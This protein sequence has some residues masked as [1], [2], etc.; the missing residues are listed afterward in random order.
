MEVT[1]DASGSSDTEGGIVTLEWDCVGDG[2]FEAESDWTV[3]AG[4]AHTCTYTVDGTYEP[5]VRATN[6]LVSG[7][8]HEC[9]QVINVMM[10]QDGRGQDRRCATRTYRILGAKP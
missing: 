5:S 10:G 4:R 3:P 7:I 1:L 2:A 9:C 6:S 8:R